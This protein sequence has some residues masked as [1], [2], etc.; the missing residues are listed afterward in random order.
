MVV[1]S[2]VRIP[3]GQSV[4]LVTMRERTS[5]SVIAGRLE[6]RSNWQWGSVCN[7]GFDYREASVACRQ[8]GFSSYRDFGTV[9]ISGKG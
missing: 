3:A 5:S 6:I 1:H 8:L 9:G 7:S 2:N 4:R